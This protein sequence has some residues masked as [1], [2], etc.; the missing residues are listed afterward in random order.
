[1]RHKVATV[2]PD[3]SLREVANRM[4]RYRLSAVA[5]IDDAERLL[6]VI[7][8]RDLIKAAL[9][10]YKSLISN[11]NYS[12][13]VEP[14][15]EL[16]KK[17]DKLKVSQLF[18]DEFEVTTPGTKIVE[19]AAMMIF[20]DIRRVFVTEGEQLVGVLLRKDIVNMVIRG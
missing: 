11:L 9:P 12:I 14:F 19:V 16:L 1:M 8:D 7:N 2:T 20:K 10:D 18:R 17:E 13:D 15:E 4:F 3:D 6:G 5:V